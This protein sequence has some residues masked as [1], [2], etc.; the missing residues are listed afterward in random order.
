LGTATRGQHRRNRNKG[1]RRAL[2]DKK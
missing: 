1:S 2:A